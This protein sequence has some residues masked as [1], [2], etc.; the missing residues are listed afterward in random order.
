[1]LKLIFLKVVGLM[2]LAGFV[3]ELNNGI[4]NSELLIKVAIT[5]VAYKILMYGAIF[6]FNKDASIKEYIP[7]FLS[8]K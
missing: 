8:L 3:L 7:K 1:M 6:S 4:I 5:Y 2:L